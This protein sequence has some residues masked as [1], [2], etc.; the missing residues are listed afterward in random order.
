MFCQVTARL[1]V[2]LVV[3][4]IVAVVLAGCATSVHR[5]V[6]TL[7]RPSGNAQIVLMP[8][9]VELY[10]LTAGGLNDPR[11]DWTTAA[12]SNL[13]AA[14]ETEQE[15]MGLQL[16]RFDD[17]RMDSKTADRLDQLQK[18]HGAV[19]NS[20][21]VHQ[22]V[23]GYELP[24]KKGR[25]DWTLGPE[26]NA[27]KSATGAD[28]ALFT[29]IRDS[30]TSTGRAALIVFAAL[31]GVAVQGGKQVGFASLVDLETG[32]IV[33]FNLL[34]RESGDLREPEPALE[35]AKTLLAGFPQ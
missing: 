24:S 8:I 16:A 29:Y 19:G 2:P 3:A 12:K 6:E 5:Q 27:M 21:V 20:I 9:D 34:R 26:A 32:E 25:F 31:F 28:Y 10:E 22:Y 35:T 17:S 14:F 4:I 30:Y 1:R 7:R 33:W 11:A 13:A 15:T 23:T 18:L